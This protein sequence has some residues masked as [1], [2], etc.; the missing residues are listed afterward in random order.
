[1]ELNEGG[2]GVVDCVL[3][4]RRNRKGGGLGGSGLVVEVGWVRGRDKEEK[5]AAEGRIF[6]ENFGT[7]DSGRRGSWMGGP[8]E[9]QGRL[10]G[11]VGV[12]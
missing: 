4:R 11:P 8:G 2:G 9:G 1:M 10:T 7:R 5:Y 3:V 12:G 6:G